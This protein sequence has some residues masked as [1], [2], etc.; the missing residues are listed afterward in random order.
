MMGRA[1]LIDVSRSH[2]QNSGVPIGEV[3]PDRCADRKRLLCIDLL[4]VAEYV[5]PPHDVRISI[6]RR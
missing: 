4:L 3:P 6:W 2:H 1:G 5:M